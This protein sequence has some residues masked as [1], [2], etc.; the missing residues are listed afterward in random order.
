MPNDSSQFQVRKWR[1]MQH[2]FCEREQLGHR[3]YICNLM[4]D[5]NHMK[6]SLITETNLLWLEA[7]FQTHS[8]FSSNKC[9]IVKLAKK[10]GGVKSVRPMYLLW[11]IY[12]HNNISF[13][14]YLVSFLIRLGFLKGI[15]LY[16]YMY[17]FRFE[18][19]YKKMSHLFSKWGSFIP[20]PDK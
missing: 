6:I 7:V 2:L 3:T 14:L 12:F 15:H 11:K 20:K 8:L 10:S 18:R 1:F 9:S 13:V 5:Q 4:P 19:Y 17:G 16:M